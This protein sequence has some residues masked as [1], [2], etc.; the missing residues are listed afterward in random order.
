MAR[1]SAKDGSASGG[2]KAPAALELIVRAAE[3]KKALDLKIL[4]VRQSSALLD[5]LVICGAD[6]Q[7]QL[8]AIAKEI[9]ARLRANGFKDFRWE[10]LPGSGWL[11]L[12]L[13]S[14]VVHLL[15]E[16]ERAY[17]K[18][19]ELWGKEAVVYHY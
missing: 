17:Y 19:E 7:P 16:E 18:L 10:G 6:S 9:E 4:D 3:S 2:K 12:D 13:G 11:I 8:R 5:Y 14:I 15:K 1:K